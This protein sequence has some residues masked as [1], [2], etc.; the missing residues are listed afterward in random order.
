M[1]ILNMKFLLKAG[2]HDLECPLKYQVFAKNIKTKNKLFTNVM[3]KAKSEMSHNDLGTFSGI[4]FLFCHC[5]L[6]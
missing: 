1:N 3:T 6:Q 4:D 2:K 5:S